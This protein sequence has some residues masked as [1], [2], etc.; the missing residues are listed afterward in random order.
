MRASHVVSGGWPDDFSLFSEDP[1]IGTVEF[2]DWPD[3][4]SVRYAATRRRPT[5]ASLERRRLRIAFW[6][7]AS[8]SRG[9]CVRLVSV[10]DVDAKF[11][12]AWEVFART[13]AS[14]V[15][16]EATFQA[17]FAHYLISQFGIDRVAREPIFKHKDL[18]STW[19]TLVPGGE[20]KLD[21]VVLREPGVNLPHYVRRPG[22]TSSDVTGMATLGD[23][24]VISELKIGA[25][26]GGGLDHREVAQDVYKLSLLLE[27]TE[28]R[29]IRSPLAY[30]GILDNNPS[31][32][33]R[34][35]GLDRRLAAVAHHHGVKILWHPAEH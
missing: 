35:E 8:T 27:E 26:A 6:L 1:R 22:A 14:A 19:Q 2:P 9:R 10:E 15:A 23:L 16:P 32:R 7:E 29:G 11:R 5:A 13:C 4:E 30:L 12:A 17:W 33:Y 28:K 18:G 20:V 21:A 24:A 3:D 25:T 31:K 34:R